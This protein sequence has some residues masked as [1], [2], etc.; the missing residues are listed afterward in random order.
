MNQKLIDTSPVCPA[1]EVADSHQFYHVPDVPVHQVKLVHSREEALACPTGDIGLRFCRNCGF[2]WNAAFDVSRMTYDEHY[3]STQAVS[4]TFNDFHDR[5]ARYVIDRFDVRGKKVVEIG[6]GQGEFLMM[7]SDYGDNIGIGFDRVNRGNSSHERVEFIKDVYSERYRD[8]EPDFVACKMTLEHVDD[9]QPFLRRVRATV[10]DRP[11]ALVFFMIPEVTRILNLRAFWDIY[12]EH[13]SYW[14]PGALARAFRCA[15]FDPV[16]V[17]TDFADQYVLITARPGNGQ[18]PVLRN[19]LP[20]S[21]LE[22]RVEAFERE[23]P[24]DIERW[25][26]WLRDFGRRGKKLVLWGGGSKGVAFLTTLG[27]KVEDGVEFAVDVNHRR[28]NTFIAGC[29]QRIVSPEFLAEYRPDV[30]LVMSPIYL[31]EIAAQLDRMGVGG[32]QLLSVESPPALQETERLRD[33]ERARFA[34]REPLAAG[35]QPGGSYG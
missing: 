18:S 7:L 2:V 26:A 6:C 16:D 4:P 23:V 31:D 20:A 15:G 32:V 27:I 33:G 19:E 22:R 14:S 3:E 8:V 5:L 24:S 1:C 11:E 30:V 10:G 13:C 29:G 34:V 28:H 17:W 9:I 25:R 12:Y 35:A 21:D